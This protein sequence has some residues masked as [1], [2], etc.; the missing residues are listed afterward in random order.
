VYIIIFS[1][2]F[3]ETMDGLIPMHPPTLSLSQSPLSPFIVIV[4]FLM[5]R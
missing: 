2:N 1:E 5:T 3:S 4:S